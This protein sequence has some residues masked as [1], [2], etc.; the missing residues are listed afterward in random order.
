MNDNSLHLAMLNSYDIVIHKVPFSQLQITDKEFFM[1][2]VTKKI[3]VK[4]IEDLL[5][6]FE[7][8]EDYEKCSRLITVKPNYE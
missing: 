6:Y 1:H 2:D 3:T 4:V 5:F 8:L 7:D